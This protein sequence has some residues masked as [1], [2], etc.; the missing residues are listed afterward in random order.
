M[1]TGNRRLLLPGRV[2]TVQANGKNR[3]L[4]ARSLAV[5]HELLAVLATTATATAM[6]VT[7]FVQQWQYDPMDLATQG[8]C[9]CPGADAKHVESH[10]ENLRIKRLTRRT[11]QVAGLGLAARPGGLL[12][13]HTAMIR[14]VLSARRSLSQNRSRS[15][16]R[17][18]G[19]WIQR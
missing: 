12:V 1:A 18:Q 19:F 17:R 16:G 2:H 11:K 15:Q 9:Q 5:E 13:L 6:L 8:C 14:L 3:C 10:G 7:C 4:N